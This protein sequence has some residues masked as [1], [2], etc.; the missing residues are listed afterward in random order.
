MAASP[1]LK[2]DSA[3]FGEIPQGRGDLGVRGGQVA[4]LRRP[5]EFIGNAAELAQETIS[6]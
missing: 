4:L 3:H 6:G 5:A 2:A 1:G